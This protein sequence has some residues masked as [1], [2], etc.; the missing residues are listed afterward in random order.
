MKENTSTLQKN[1]AQ[2]N[3]AVAWER[4][5]DVDE[6]KGDDGITAVF[7]AIR[8]DNLGVLKQ[9][10]SYGADFNIEC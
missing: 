1:E 3:K 8:F 10:R 5:I 7:Y 6:Q 2:I 4:Q 9:L